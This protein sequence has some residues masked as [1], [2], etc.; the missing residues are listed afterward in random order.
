MN[1][2]EYKLLLRQPESI[3]ADQTAA[4]QMVIKQYPF[5]QSAYAMRLKG[6]YNDNSYQYNYTL[7]LAAAYTTDRTVL[8]DFITSE[9]FEK[10]SNSAIA[11]EEVEVIAPRA[12]TAEEKEVEI[13]PRKQ[14]I[15]DSIEN[16]E[17]ASEEFE[18]EDQTSEADKTP[19]AEQ[20]IIESIESAEISAEEIEVQNDSNSEISTGDNL[21]EAK[22]TKLEEAI[23][24]EISVEEELGTPLEFSTSETHSFKEWLRLSTVQPIVREEIREEKKEL[25]E[26][27]LE[28][29][30]KTDLINKFIIA[31]PKIPPVKSDTRTPVVRE[32]PADTSA[33]MTETLAR[34]YLEQ[35]KYQKAIQA[36]QILIL[37][38]PEKSSFFANRISDIKKIQQNN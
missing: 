7:K 1:L 36:Y 30:K 26:T 24:K 2:Q 16:A 31:S 27:E 15:L 38:Y 6:L 20:S 21:A 5:L 32:T 37:K 4:L 35:K 9:E 14:S 18:L 29:I 11:E 25:S 8:F 12:E 34:V 17:I 22:E 28:K 33:L 19:S 23:S 10:V 13:K 3:T